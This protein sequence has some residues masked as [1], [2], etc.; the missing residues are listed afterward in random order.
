MEQVCRRWLTSWQEA[1]YSRAQLQQVCK[2]FSA[3]PCK[4]IQN[5][6]LDVQGGSVV[7]AG[8][9]KTAHTSPLLFTSRKARDE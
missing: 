9:P 3:C 8:T 6:M 2:D 5:P 4:G 1:L 7:N